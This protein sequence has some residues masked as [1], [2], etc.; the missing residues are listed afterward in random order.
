MEYFEVALKKGS[1]I[2]YLAFS[3]ALSGSYQGSV[4]AAGELME[5]YPERR[6]LCIDTRAASAG[7]GMLVYYAAQKKAEGMDMDSL[8]AWVES[9]KL[10][11][12]HWFTVDD[13][14][15]L[16]R[17]GRIS[18]MSWAVGSMLNIKPVLH[19]DNEG[20]L[21]SMGKTRGR[22][23]SLKALVDKMEELAIEPGSQTP[24]ISHGDCL[25]DVQKVVDD[26]KA[27]FGVK[28]VIINNVGPVIGAHA[29]A[30]VVALFFLGT[31]R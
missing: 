2:L 22:A 13:L 27:R 31:Q 4:V 3:S 29:G 17:G 6:I 21:I 18:A 1:D 24:F 5:K 25:E 10:K 14:H 9:N 26:I 7:E 15:T 8:A 30:G 19:V 16:R 11:M 23:A 20:H 12:C 28:E